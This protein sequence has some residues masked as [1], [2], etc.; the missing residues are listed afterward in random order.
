[1]ACLLMGGGLIGA[2][3]LQWDAAADRVSAD[4]SGTPL[5]SVLEQI[6]VAT[7]WEVAV[8][9]GVAQVVA[10]TFSGLKSGKA[11]A[12]LLRPASFA[13]LHRTNAA[14]RLLVFK[15]AMDRATQPILETSEADSDATELIADELIVTLRPGTDAAE[16]ARKLG[17][18]VTGSIDK[19]GAYRFKF[20]DADAARAAR[21]ALN[22]EPTVERVD[23]NYAIDRPTALMPLMHSNGQLPQIKPATAGVDGRLVIGLVDTAVQL[24]VGELAE[25][26]LEPVSLAGEYQP[27]GTAPTHG[28]GMSSDILNAVASMVGAGNTA[29]VAIL[30]IDVFG[31]GES[32]STFQLGHGLVEAWNR[33]AT[34][35]NG[36]I[37][38]KVESLWLTEVINRLT[39]YGAV[40]VAPSGNSPDGLP[41]YPAAHPGVLAV[42]A[43]GP[44]GRLA[45]YANMA[46]FVDVAMPGS[47]IVNLTG[48]PYFMAGTSV[49]TARATGAIAG[50]SLRSG[51]SLSAAQ[52]YLRQTR[53]VHRGAQIS[54]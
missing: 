54:P 2:E 40:L 37:G 11:L 39:G 22:G 19:L 33:G 31:A 12:R 48:S 13:L 10:T 3:E 51:Q 4:L 36:S 38:S 24:P 26:F 34:L 52:D 17:A 16:L 46:S 21:D 53:G 30:P 5:Q 6:R 8:E 27:T 42:T 1:M 44:D 50:Y 7:G 18:T 25:F 15:T 23:A 43:V 47:S 9:P 32:T 20:L 45:P 35:I 28:T 14:A 49:A 41:T 29:N